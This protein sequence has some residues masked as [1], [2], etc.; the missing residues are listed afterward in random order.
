MYDSQIIAGL[1]I[2]R[3]IMS[4]CS[5]FLVNFVTFAFI[6][7]LREEMKE[8]RGRLR[9]QT[10][11]ESGK[12]TKIGNGTETERGMK[13]GT[14]TEE[15][16]G[17]RTLL[18]TVR[19]KEVMITSVSYD[20]IIFKL[21]MLFTWMEVTLFYFQGEKMMRWTPWIQVLI[22]MPQGTVFTVMIIKALGPIFKGVLQIY[23]IALP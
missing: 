18:R 3:P 6:F 7:Q 1:I 8:L 20:T 14:E 5:L 9:S 12:E 10:E 16:W 4:E 19:T 21:M 11:S 22:L 23:C 2:T 13:G 17:E 15:S